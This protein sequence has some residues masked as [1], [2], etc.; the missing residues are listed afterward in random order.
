MR[1]RGRNAYE[2]KIGADAI[3]TFEIV[4]KINNKRTIKSLLFQAKKEGNSSGLASQKEKMD[5]V[6]CKG[7]FIFTCSEQE[8]YA[9][10]EI[11]GQRTNIESF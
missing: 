11:D 3:I 1:G 7:N 4:D 2:S 6:A 8:Y 10:T 5:K 9:Q